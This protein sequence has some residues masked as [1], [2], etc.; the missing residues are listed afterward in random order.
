MQECSTLLE[1]LLCNHAGFKIVQGSFCG[2]FC[3]PRPSPRPRDA[4][5]FCFTIALEAALFAGERLEL[6]CS[7]VEVHLLWLGYDAE[8]RPP[9]RPRAVRTAVTLS[10]SSGV[11]LSLH[12][13]SKWVGLFCSTRSGGAVFQRWNNFVS[14]C[15]SIMPILYAADTGV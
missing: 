15:S 2:R 5:Q 9:W 7:T 13:S 4:C 6:F 11:G 12:S 1:F 14:S 8:D 3:V 10:T